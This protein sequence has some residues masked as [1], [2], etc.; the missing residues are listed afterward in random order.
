MEQLVERFTAPTDA[1]RLVLTQAARELLLMQS[2]DWQFLITTGQ[3]RAY[4]VRRFVE[5][6]EHFDRLAE[7]LETGEPNVA[8]AEMYRNEAN[9]FAEVDYRWFKRNSAED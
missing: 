8:L 5:Y 1:E 4:A 3:G 9:V 6:A 7:S 2:S